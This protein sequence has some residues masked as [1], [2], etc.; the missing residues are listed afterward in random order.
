MA[1]RDVLEELVKY[2]SVSPLVLGGWDETLE[3]AIEL[4]RPPVPTMLR[5]VLLGGGIL[6]GVD[7]FRAGLYVGLGS[8]GIEAIV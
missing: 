8:F 3:A 7:K 2:E 6:A 1:V 5:A 4:L